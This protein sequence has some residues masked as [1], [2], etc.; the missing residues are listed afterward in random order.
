MSDT[1][2]KPQPPPNDLA[3]D[4]RKDGPGRRLWKSITAKYTLRPDELRIL[5]SACRCDDAI[6]ELHRLRAEYEAQPRY[7]EFLVRGSVGQSVEN[8][9]RARVAKIIDDI[10]NQEVTQA[11][12]LSKLKLPDLDGAAAGGQAGQ[13]EQ[14][15][16]VGARAA[17]NSRWGKTG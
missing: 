3:R 7:A 10:R 16:S 9:L 17:A 1:T 2:P 11:G 8:P 14:P 12:H 5:H 6:A 15:R 13:D 4:G